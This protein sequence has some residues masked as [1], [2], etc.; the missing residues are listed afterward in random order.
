MLHRTS[1]GRDFTR[2]KHKTQGPRSAEIVDEHHT[3]VSRNLVILWGQILKGL[4]KTSPGLLG[5]LEVL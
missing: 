1:L 4:G 3:F 2:I 5:S